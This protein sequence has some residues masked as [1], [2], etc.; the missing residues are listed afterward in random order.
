MTKYQTSRG[1]GGEVGLNNKDLLSQG[2]RVQ[3]SK[4]KVPQDHAPSEGAREGALPGLCLGFW[5]FL[6]L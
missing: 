6:G 3:K 4:V 5:E 1:G 2:S